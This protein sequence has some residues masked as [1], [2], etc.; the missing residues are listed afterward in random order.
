MLLREILKTWL[1]DADR[2]LRR[3]G[4]E[5]MFRAQGDAQRLEELLGYLEGGAEKRLNDLSKPRR[6]VTYAP[7]A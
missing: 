5:E 3:L 4:G 2:S 1:A 7:H 6:P